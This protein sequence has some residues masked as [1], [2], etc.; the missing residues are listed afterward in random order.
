MN[1]KLGAAFAALGLAASIASAAGDDEL[2]EI[3]S[4]MSMPGLPSGM[5]ASTQ[6]ICRDKDPAKS[7]APG[8][9]MEKC[10]IVD[11][12]QSGNRYTMT[13]RCPEGTAVFEQTYDAAR[14]EFKGSMKMSSRDGE[15]VLNMSGR[16][17]GSCDAQQ[18]RSAQ[19]AQ[20][21]AAKAQGEQILAQSRAHAAASEERQIRDCATAVDAM[22]VQKLGMYAH[23]SSNQAICDQM[24][25]NEQS[26]RSA[27]ACMANATEY[28]KRYQTME[29]FLKAKGDQDGARMCNVSREELGK[30]FCPRA[31]QTENLAYLGRFCPAEAKVVAQQH[32]VGRSFTSETKDK[33]SDFCTSYLADNSI[34]PTAQPAA[35][36]KDPKDAITEG[37]SQGINKLKGLFGR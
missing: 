16:K 37:V 34:E 14:S 3:T 28:C 18:A 17:I 24:L 8:K 29:G 23:C 9:D 21:A 33:Y 5:G 36:R 4:Q 35:A 2:W 1:F 20:A 30:S 12:K 15:M 22:Q 10:K 26:K 27:K 25:A 6:Q 7:T 19:E 11:S 31:A 32:C 13:M